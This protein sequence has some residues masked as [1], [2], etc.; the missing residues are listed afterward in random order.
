LVALH[1]GTVSARVKA[2]LGLLVVLFLA[3]VLAAVQ[4]GGMFQGSADDPGI[5]YQT[6]ALRND[7]VTLNQKLQEGAV[8]LAFEG[9]SGYLR[10]ALAALEIPVD[11]QMLVFS[12]TSLQSARINAGN[13]RALF[14]SDRVALGW[15]RDGD[16]LEV[17]AHDARQG[18]VFYTLEQR[19]T[20]MPQFKRQ[21]ICLGCHRGGPTLGVPGLLMFSTRA[22]DAQSFAR[23][24]MMDHRSPL[25]ERW[26]G[27]FVT[28]SSGSTAHLGNMVERLQDMQTREL[29]SVDSLFDPDGY[30]SRF[31]DI[32]A[33]L[34]FSHQIH[35]VNLLTRASWE[36]R[37]ADPALHPPYIADPAEQQRIADMMRGIAN[38]V[39]DYLLFIDEAPLP[40]GVHGSSGF[41]ERFSAIGPHDR[42]GRSL[43]ELDL[44]RRVMKYPCSYVIYS[45]AF[46]AL[47]PAVKDP[48]FQRIWQIL[49]G[50]E[51]AARY[52]SALSR[53]DR[54]AIVEILRHTMNDLPPYFQRVQR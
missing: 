39:V 24:V 22:A 15:V 16:V 1:N 54:E 27:W 32:A 12:Q 53:A 23:S 34:V 17:A 51:H 48:I 31:S 5:M 9:L 37:A 40:Q 44:E 14:F 45:P 50:E 2:T 20:E 42:E 30:Q 38:E 46:D 28:G 13:P 43:H 11:S 52:R 25:K 47:P 19:A 8:H 49:S 3:S 26:G 36:A 29:S 18:V 41:T 10:S 33:L 21:T 35:M 4:R 7:V 6:A